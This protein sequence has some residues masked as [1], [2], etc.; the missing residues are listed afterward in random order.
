MISTAL[1]AQ[2]LLEEDNRETAMLSML[3]FANEL[4]QR[5][6]L[7]A[8]EQVEEAAAV[9]Q[10]AQLSNTSPRAGAE[11]D[12]EDFFNGIGPSPKGADAEND[13]FFS[14]LGDTQATS[15]LRSHRSGISDS[16]ALEQDGAGEADIQRFLFV[17]NHAAAID[18]CM[19]HERFADALVI[20]HISGHGDLWRSTLMRY[21]QHCPHPYLRIVD[22]Q[23]CCTTHR[24]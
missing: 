23:V 13:D 8:S 3:G 2:V 17:G 20:A 11:G 10:R 4:V 19:S 9:L 14:K 1:C 24:H 22:S 21:M 18:S 12:D 15:T 16:G 6:A 7:A 5:S